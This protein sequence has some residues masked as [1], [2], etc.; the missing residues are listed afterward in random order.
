MGADI[1]HNARVE[2]LGVYLSVT[3][4]APPLSVGS[5]KLYITYR[6]GSKSIPYKNLAATC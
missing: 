3:Q 2:V 4:G 6:S 1:K 5:R